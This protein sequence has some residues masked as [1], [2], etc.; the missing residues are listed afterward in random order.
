MV[1]VPRHLLE[2]TAA[3]SKLNAGDRGPWQWHKGSIPAGVSGHQV[4]GQLL[5]CTG[6]R[7]G[8]SP[9]LP[10]QALRGT[11]SWEGLWGQGR[12][13]GEGKVN[14]CGF[15]AWHRDPGSHSGKGAGGSVQWASPPQVPAPGPRGQG[16]RLSSTPGAAAGIPAAPCKLAQSQQAG[17]NGQSPSTHL[18]PQ[19]PAGPLGLQGRGFPKHPAAHGLSCETQIIGSINSS[20]AETTAE[21]LPAFPELAGADTW[22]EGQAHPRR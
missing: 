5:P 17:P 22:G 4:Q 9:A 10:M 15:M 14:F 13:T 21:P 8:S 12:G 6:Q 18:C 20:G 1:A 3:T 2:G 11:P 19:H 16:W 7:A